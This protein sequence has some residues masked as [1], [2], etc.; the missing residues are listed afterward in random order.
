[1]P[2]VSSPTLEAPDVKSPASV[3]TAAPAPTPPPAA[4]VAAPPPAPKKSR[5]SLVR[6]T[7]MLGGIVAVVVGAGLFWLS[8]G[9][10]VETDNSYVGAHMVMVAPVVTGA[11]TAVSVTEGAVVAPGDLLFTI[12][13]EPYR[14]AV[15]SAQSEL[16]AAEI[17]LATLKQDYLKSLADITVEERQVDYWQREVERTQSLVDRKAA[18]EADLDRDRLE[19]TSA[20]AQVEALRQATQQTLAA[21]AGNP[22]LP[23]ESYP[24]WQTAKAKLDGAERD[25]RNTEVRATIGGIATQTDRVLPGRYLAAGTTALS[26]VS[27]EDVW[28]DANPKETDLA[29]VVEGQTAEVTIDAYP[30][31]TFEGTVASI[32]PGTGSQFALLPAQNASANWVKVVQ[33]VPV[34]IALALHEGDP[35]LRAGMSADV[36]IDTGRTRSLSDLF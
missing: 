12:D 19:L 16:A 35:P 2:D 34:R 33:R 28:V 6:R 11:I 18:S 23:L 20:Q 30:G 17:A 3:P 15:A 31:R 9:R 32:S 13:P 26:I 27:T 5:R 14:I 22:D 24:A 7:L 1:M 36:S 10:Y 25:L 21:L 8:G 29:G 4:V